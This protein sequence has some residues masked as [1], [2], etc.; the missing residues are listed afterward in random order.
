MAHILKQI[1]DTPNIPF[2]MF[3]C[4]DSSDLKDISLSMVPMGSRCYVINE[5]KTYALNSKQEWKL[6]P[7]S[8]SGSGGG[9][10]EPSTP[11]DDIIYDGG[12]ED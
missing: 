9:S 6:V 2:Y 12:S 3:E 8:G 10:D 11:S 4:D 5:G 1:G 7:S